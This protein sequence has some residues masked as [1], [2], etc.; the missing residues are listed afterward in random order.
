MPVES[1]SFELSDEEIEFLNAIFDVVRA[2]HLAKLTS[3]LDQ[4]IPVDF[5][6]AKGDSLL[7]L[8]AYHEHTQLVELLLSREAN[9]DALNDRGQTPLVCAVFRN[10]EEITKILLDAGADPQ[11]GH[12]TPAE[13]A[14]F[15]NLPRM[16]ELLAG[17]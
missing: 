3:L 16:K 11:L 5:T 9:M 12:Q 10:N 13:V 15:F 2:G 8:A 7:I 4:G 14:D 17:K 6:D 1:T